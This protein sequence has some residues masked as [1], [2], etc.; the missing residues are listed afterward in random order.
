MCFGNLCELL[1]N[2][3]DSYPQDKCR[4]FQ[5]KLL[6][7]SSKVLLVSVYTLPPLCRVHLYYFLRGKNLNEVLQLNGRRSSRGVNFFHPRESN[8]NL[9]NIT[10]VFWEIA[11]FPRR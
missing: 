3:V 7:S 8:E 11:G 10:Y 5:T 4:N 2:H 1:K 6:E 9:T